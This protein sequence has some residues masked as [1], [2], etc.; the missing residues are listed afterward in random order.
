MSKTI[1]P[2]VSAHHNCKTSNTNAFHKKN[3]ELRDNKNH[4]N[5]KKSA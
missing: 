1:S 5:T 2:A 4:S 3:S